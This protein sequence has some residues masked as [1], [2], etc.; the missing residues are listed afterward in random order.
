MQY[1]NRFLGRGAEGEESLIEAENKKSHDIFKNRLLL[2]SFLNLLNFLAFIFAM[3]YYN[4]ATAQL[5]LEVGEQ[6]LFVNLL[7]GKQLTSNQY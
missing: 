5:P 2:T 1:W 4:W 3:A 6:P 7:Y